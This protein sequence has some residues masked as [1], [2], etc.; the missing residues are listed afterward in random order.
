MK[1]L[2]K[3]VSAFIRVKSLVSL[4]YPSCVWRDFGVNNLTYTVRT[5]QGEEFIFD[6][7]TGSVVGRHPPWLF[8]FGLTLAGDVAALGFATVLIVG[9]GRQSHLPSLA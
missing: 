3:G 9:R 7:T 4:R 6:V 5:N 1:F 2:K 8:Y